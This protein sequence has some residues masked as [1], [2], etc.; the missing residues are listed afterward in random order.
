MDT[1]SALTAYRFCK[2]PVVTVGLN[3]VDFYQPIFSGV[4]CIFCPFIVFTSSKSIEVKI[5]VYADDVLNGF[6]NFSELLDSSILLASAYFTFVSIG[7]DKIP[8]KVPQL[9]LFS[10]DEKIIFQ[11]RLDYYSN[12]KRAQNSK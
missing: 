12:R 6:D 11:Q 7:K 1:L 3:S 2:S 8:I 5:N 10:E 9:I 4:I